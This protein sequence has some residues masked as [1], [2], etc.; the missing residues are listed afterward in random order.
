MA[1][2]TMF[3]KIKYACHDTAVIQYALCQV[4]LADQLATVGLQPQEVQG[5]LQLRAQA[6]PLDSSSIR[7]DLA[8]YQHVTWLNDLEKV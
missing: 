8:P 6:V 7:I 5:L 1:A 3:H 4:R 2:D